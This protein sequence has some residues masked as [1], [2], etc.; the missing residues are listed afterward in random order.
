MGFEVFLQCVG[1]AERSGIP[2]AGVRS[3]FPIVEEESEPDYWSVRYDN[4]NSC[5]IGVTAAASDREM[6][7]SLYVDR[8]CGD[9]RLWEGLHSVL[10]TGPVVIYWP[11]G[12][13]VVAR[14]ATAELLPKEMVEGL[15]PAQVAASGE[16]LMR[17]VEGLGAESGEG[18]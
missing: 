9:T 6:L 14:R 12:P 15:G 8:P 4:G 1:D 16:E 2:R 18:V 11:G 3:L 17:M 13:P 10:R 7:T 5:H